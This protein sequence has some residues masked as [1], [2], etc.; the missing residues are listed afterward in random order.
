MRLQ[1]GSDVSVDWEAVVGAGS[2]ELANL[3][4]NLKLLH[5]AETKQSHHYWTKRDQIEKETMMEKSA[6]W[7]SF[8]EATTRRR[9]LLVCASQS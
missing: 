7:E 2:L 9:H 6:A 1:P 8:R 5:G 4:Q 3:R